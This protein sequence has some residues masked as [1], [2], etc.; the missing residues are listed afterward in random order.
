METDLLYQILLS[1]LVIGVVSLILVLLRAYQ[2]LS[3]VRNATFRLSKRVEQIDNLID[4]FGNRMKGIGELIFGFISSAV[5]GKKAKEAVEEF[6]SENN[7][8]KEE[9]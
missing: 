5:G 2:V 3:D 8:P 9:K 4:L 1:V 7:R 6:W